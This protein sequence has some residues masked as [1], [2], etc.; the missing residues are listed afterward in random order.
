[1]RSATRGLSDDVDQR[2][3]I[4]RQS[5]AVDEPMSKSA[6]D[7]AAP[8]QAA[9]LAL[10]QEASDPR[11]ALKDSAPAFDETSSKVAEDP[12]V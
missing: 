8:S 7:P 9:S 3:Q 10:G 5:D 2:F 6:E 12:T 4:A 1:M 11:F